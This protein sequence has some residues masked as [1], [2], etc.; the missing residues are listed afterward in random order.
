[1][2]DER[3]H[4]VQLEIPFSQSVWVCVWGGRTERNP[5]VI[6]VEERGQNIENGVS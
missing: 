6:V 5:V 2:S 1:M 4:R 3:R